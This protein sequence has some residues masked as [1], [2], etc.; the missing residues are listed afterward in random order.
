[1]QCAPQVSMQVKYE[2]YS[3]QCDHRV[4]D[5]C[6][7]CF[8]II[9]IGSKHIFPVVLEKNLNW[10][11]SIS[12]KLRRIGTGIVTRIKYGRTE[13][14]QRVAKQ[15]EML[16]LRR[17]TNGV[18]TANWNVWIL[19]AQIFSLVT[20]GRSLMESKISKIQCAAGVMTSVR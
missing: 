12:G 10:L 2:K 20:C 11:L 13:T 19:S 14:I 18:P 8:F 9:Q 16:S 7:Y 3:F 6:L 17:D 15:L 1:M 4:Y 5:S